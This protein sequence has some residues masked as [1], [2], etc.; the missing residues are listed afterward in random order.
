MAGIACSTADAE[1]TV[2]IQIVPEGEN[3][4]R[5]PPHA[6]P[7]PSPQAL[8]VEQ[9]LGYASLPGWVAM[10][11]V[12]NRDKDRYHLIESFKRAT[13]EQIAEIV[14]HLR[15]LPPVYLKE[16]ERLVRAAEDENQEN[17]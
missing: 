13:P 6:P 1:G 2:E 11:L 14:V 10:K 8:G 16:F 9:G 12:A 17:W 3:S 5:D 15:T 7:N 4:P